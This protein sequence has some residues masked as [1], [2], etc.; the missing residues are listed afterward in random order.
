MIEIKY[1][2]ELTT[3]EFEYDYA[4]NVGDEDADFQK[5]EIGKYPLIYINGV[6]VENSNIS[7]LTIHN[8][9]MYPSLDMTFTDPTSH[10]MLD[11][12]PV[13]DTIVSLY[14]KATSDGLMDI[15]MDFKIIKFSVINGVSGDKI[16]LKI[17]AIINIDKLYL[18][19]FES[20]EDTS[21]NVLD[22]LASEMELGFASNIAGTS[23]DMKWINPGD[24]R[25]NFIDNIIKNSYIDDTTYL[26][27]YIDFYYNFNY[28]DINKQLNSDISTQVTINDTEKIGDDLKNDPIPLILSNHKDKKETT[29]Y[30]D[31]YTINQDSTKINI[32][33]GY[34]YRYSGYDKT[35]DKYSRYYIDSI[36]EAGNNG[37][38][39]KG[40]PFT[41]DGILYEESIRDRWMGKLDTYN[42]HEN[43][44]HTE[45][46]NQ[47]NLKFLQKLKM[48]IKMGKP[49]NALYRF[50]KVLVEIYNM[51]K[52][53]TEEEQNAEPPKLG[54]EGG[55]DAKINNYLSGEWLI[56]AINVTFTKKESNVQEITLVKRELTEE[57]TFPRREKK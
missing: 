34:R 44:L 30:I 52:M 25:L 38:V 50:Q 51:G 26:Y 1:R 7:E 21:Y 32:D 54:K 14:K 5:D 23:D 48:T 31:K 12:Y 29:L 33:T 18:F 3:L 43:Y 9:Q 40:N 8:N 56:T 36:S 6:Q 35:E 19:N 53:N 27:G 57:Y 49:N 11:K 22:T 45:L 17:N 10:L 46:Q 37:I 16:T 2:A 41:E 55:D 47:N 42:V 13:D 4:D 28:V 39:L 20:Y 15:K 24:Y